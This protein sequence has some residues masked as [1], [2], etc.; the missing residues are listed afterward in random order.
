MDDWYA[1]YLG[2]GA[3][4]AGRTGWVGQISGTVPEEK[5]LSN[6]VGSPEYYANSQTRF[7]SGDANQKYIQALYLVV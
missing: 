4:D 7:V 1:R 3:D 2:R 5:A 6:I